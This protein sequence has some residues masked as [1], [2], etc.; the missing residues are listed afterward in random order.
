MSTVKRSVAPAAGAR[1]KVFRATAGLTIDQQLQ[2]ASQLKAEG[3]DVLKTIQQMK[4]ATKSQKQTT[5]ANSLK[6]EWFQEHSHMKKLEENCSKELESMLLRMYNEASTARESKKL[7]PQ[8]TPS[9]GGATLHSTRDILKIDEENNHDEEEGSIPTSASVMS[10]STIYAAELEDL[11]RA[12]QLNRI[13]LIK[14]I[15]SEREQANVHQLIYD[16]VIGRQMIEATLE[17]EVVSCEKDFD[18]CYRKV[19]EMLR[20]GSNAATESTDAHEQKI[21]KML[22]TTGGNQCSDEMLRIE[23]VEGFRGAFAVFRHDLGKYEKEFIDAASATDAA[24]R[25]DVATSKSG[26]WGDMDEERFLKVF[27]SYEKKHGAGKNPQLLYDQLALV[28]PTISPMD[29]KKHVRFHQHLRFYQEKR[30]DRQHELDRRLEELQNEAIMKFR[31]VFEQEQARICKLQQLTKMQEQCEERHELV[32]RWRVTKE[33]KERI[34]MQQREIEALMEAQQQ[35]EEAIRWKRKHDQQKLAV[36]GYK[37][38]KVLRRMAGEKLSIEEE[39]QRETERALQSVVNAERVQYRHHEFQ[40]KLDDMKLEEIHKAQLEEQRLAKLNELKEK[41]PYAQIIANITPDPERTRQETVAF[42]ANVEAAQEGL[43]LSETGL[44]PSHGYDC[45]TLFKNARFKLG[46]AL[47][48]A[49]LNSSEYAR[50][51]LANV[52]VCNVGAYRN[53]V[54][55]S[56]KLW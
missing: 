31:T 32:S 48:N 14:Q 55:E 13:A 1:K 23:V 26:G 15:T 6:F 47:R 16:A 27:R 24:G 34:E 3:D 54:P 43:P 39:Q 9:K 56:T 17:E 46:I 49:G 37:K 8:D 7:E 4:K 22:E 40:R 30:K 19:L 2:V 41:T 20:G 44:F 38:D 29:I 25:I 11:I 52:K 21:I 18:L 10:T 50:Q 36:D 45:D 51:A 35:Q 12:E 28:L 42:R 53:H 33:A 5:K